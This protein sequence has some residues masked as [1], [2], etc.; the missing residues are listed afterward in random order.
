[1]ELKAG[2]VYKFKIHKVH[3]DH[4]ELRS[5]KNE[6]ARLEKRYTYKQNFAKNQFI[7]L[8]A[9]L[10]R[11]GGIFLSTRLPILNLNEAGMLKIVD[12][13]K[14]GFFLSNGTERDIM[15][16]QDD[17]FGKVEKDQ[18]ALVKVVPGNDGMLKATMKFERR[19][20]IKDAEYHVGDRVK[21][22]VVS[23]LRTKSG[24]FK[25]VQ[26]LVDNELF[27]FVHESEMDDRV[28]LNEVV[29]ARIIFIR[30][31]KKINATLRPH[32]KDRIQLDKKRITDYLYENNGVIPFSKK[33]SSEEI[34]EI[35]DM[36]KKAFKRA[37]NELLEEGV[38]EQKEH[39][40]YLL[41]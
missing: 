11:E 13:N 7:Q 27:V 16:T 33:S 21:G 25:G 41:K 32:I 31:D 5:P 23:K 9:L 10:E 15:L 2:Q 28:R 3:E 36:S 26:L 39:K 34:I 38:I 22:R 37:L 14:A 1:M 40:T 35:F 17:Q 8:H 6:E 12:K 18:F 29:E 30:E 4:Y 24:Q 19:D 20:T